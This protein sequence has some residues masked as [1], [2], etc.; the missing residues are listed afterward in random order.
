MFSTSVKSSVHSCKE[1]IL[2]ISLIFV[3]VIEWKIRRSWQFTVAITPKQFLRNEKV[4][5]K[6]EKFIVL[7][8]FTF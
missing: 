6:Y 4:L 1:R 2:K 5:E 7:S 8:K 3:T